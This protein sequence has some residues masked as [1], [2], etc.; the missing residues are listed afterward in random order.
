VYHVLVKT[1]IDDKVVCKSEA[2]RFHRMSFTI[3]MTGNVGIVEIT[4]DHVVGGC[5]GLSALN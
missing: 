2:G 1:V 4:D 3:V 5:G